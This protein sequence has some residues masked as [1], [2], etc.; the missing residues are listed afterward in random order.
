MIGFIY[1]LFHHS[2]EDAVVLCTYDAHCTSVNLS[3]N[4]VHLKSLS[5]ILIASKDMYNFR[6]LK[7]C[8][9]TRRGSL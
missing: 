9:L 7:Q 1:F 2:K 5:D 6:I 8:F 4:I 3:I